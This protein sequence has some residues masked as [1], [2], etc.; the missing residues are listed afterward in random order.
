MWN[1][2]RKRIIHLA[3]SIPQNAHISLSINIQVDCWFLDLPFSVVHSCLEYFLLAEF[4]LWLVIKLSQ[5]A[6]D[7]K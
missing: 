2:C 4:F 7:L 1:P 5:S 3:S 6:V